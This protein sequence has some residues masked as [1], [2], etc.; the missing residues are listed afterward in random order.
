[1][2]LAQTWWPIAAK[3]E[4]NAENRKCRMIYALPEFLPLMSVYPIDLTW[5]AAK[6]SFFKT[7]GR[8]VCGPV[9]HRLCGVPNGVLKGT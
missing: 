5:P 3:A 4:N 8:Q 2:R 9:C 7:G 1:M 6:P